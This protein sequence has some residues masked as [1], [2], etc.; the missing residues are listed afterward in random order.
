MITATPEVLPLYSR[1]FPL[2]WSERLTSLQRLPSS[3]TYLEEVPA[4]DLAM[5]NASETKHNS[6][7]KIVC[8]AD[9]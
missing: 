5:R 9:V 6:K 2:G 3:S 8:C 1:S 4:Y 7:S